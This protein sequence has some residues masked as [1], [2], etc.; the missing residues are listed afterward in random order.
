M[1]NTHYP[2]LDDDVFTSRDVPHQ[3]MPTSRMPIND[4]SSSRRGRLRPE[5]PKTLQGVYPPVRRGSPLNPQKGNQV[6]DSRRRP[7]PSDVL[8]PPVD[9]TSRQR[10]NTSLGLGDNTRM[11]AVTRDP[12]LAQDGELEVGVFSNEYDLSHEDP[13]ILQDVQRALK[14]KARREARLKR[15]SPATPD[16]LDSNQSSPA[17]IPRQSPSTRPFPAQAPLSPSSSR[18]TSRKISSSTTSDVDFSPS[19]GVLEFPTHSHPMPASLD[20]GMTLDWTSTVSEDAERRW[21]ISIGKRKD[22]DKLPP[23]GVILDQQEQMHKEKLSRIRNVASTQTTRKASI[24]LEQLG[25]RYNLIYESITANNAPL[26]LAKIA[27]WY[28]SQDPLIRK[29]LEKA[30]PFTW[31]KH[32]DRRGSNTSRLPWHLSALIMEEY[33]HAQSRRDRMHSIPEDSVIP[34]SSRPYSRRPRSQ[35]YLASPYE[36]STRDMSKPAGSSADDR[37]S[38]EPRADYK[39]KSTDAGS[40]NSVESAFSSVRTGSSIFGPLSP[41][42][43]RFDDLDSRL[44]RNDRI[45]GNGHSGNSYS[46]SESSDDD[47]LKAQSS[48]IASVPDVTVEPPSFESITTATANHIP[49][50]LTISVGSSQSTNPNPIHGGPPANRSMTSLR[51]SLQP[52]RVRMSLPHASRQGRRS[53]NREESEESLRREYESKS[54]LL[55]DSIAH[56]HRVRQLLNRLSAAVKEYDS[57]HNSAVQAL[58]IVQ[59]NLP[60]DLVEAF[61]HDPSAVTG[62][63]RRLRGWRAIEDIHQ[64]VLRQRK[65][66]QAFNLPVS[67][68]DAKH[69]CLLDEPIDK[70]LRALEDLE[71]C[72]DAI[73]SQAD[74]VMNLLKSVQAVH[75]EVKEDYN[76]TVSHVSVV[77]P[78]LSYIVAL[79]ESYKDQYQQFWELG[80]DAL[81]L[82]LDTVTPFW[83]TYGK[84]IGEDVRDFLIIPLYRNEFTGE[85]KRYRIKEI[86]RRSLRHWVGLVV[87][88]FISIAINVLQVRAAISSSLHFR[89]HLIPYDGVR[90]T[91]LPFFWLGILIQWLAV[92]FEFAIVFMQLG[93]ITWWTGWCVKIST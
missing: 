41:V 43:S 69:G 24:T 57:I 92:I 10:K 77:Y 68:Y 20:N 29:S 58:G 36:G 80:M 54:L 71:R 76:S 60:K 42:S 4:S 16:N 53:K 48:I 64:R 62:A 18:A 34:D 79:E 11:D 22:K 15:E 3:R 30:E 67:E 72:K 81:T 89:L 75:A 27:R 86:P 87:F 61:G 88:F 2:A 70:I 49:L 19:V 78:E 28:G 84:T 6:M 9:S 23:L 90:W 39:K 31:L 21:A 5:A 91:A 13:R 38:F 7:W 25:R 46:E 93:V 26:N 56:N 51:D 1:E 45:S 47:R 12:S 8:V 14:M 32:L 66:F 44:P 82:L 55:Q 59:S 63:T 40:R 85:V 83:R 74:A 50:T 73:A 33:C 17:S 65:T 35:S 52:R 37:I